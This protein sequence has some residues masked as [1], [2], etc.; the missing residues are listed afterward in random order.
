M[1]AYCTAADVRRLTGVPSSI[2]SDAD[3]G[4]LIADADAKIDAKI[5]VPSPTPRQIKRLSSLLAAIDVYTR[6]DLRGG[7][8]SGDFS[9]SN[10]EIEESLRRWEREG[11]GIFSYYVKEVSYSK[12]TAYKTISEES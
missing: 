12:A 7:F 10:Q 8:S 2:I 5:T 4:E 6:P 9:V 3:L 1:V 11:E